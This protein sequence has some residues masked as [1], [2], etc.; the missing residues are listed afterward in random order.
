MD[1]GAADVDAMDAGG[2]TAAR[3]RSLRPPSQK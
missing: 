2:G 3:G 1:P